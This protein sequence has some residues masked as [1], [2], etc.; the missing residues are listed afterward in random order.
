MIFFPIAFIYLYYKLFTEEE[1][2]P[3]FPMG[4]FSASKLWAGDLYLKKAKRLN[5][6]QFNYNL[7]PKELCLYSIFVVQAQASR[8][9]TRH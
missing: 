9:Q 6:L 5:Y 4:D 7:I 8:E 1:P 2:I 3:L